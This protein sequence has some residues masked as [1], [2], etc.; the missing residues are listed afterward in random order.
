MDTV[1]MI[2]RLRSNNKSQIE[3]HKNVECTD[4]MRVE[5]NWT[6]K[7]NSIDIY[8]DYKYAFLTAIRIQDTVGR[9]PRPN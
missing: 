6:E 7:V 3:R 5:S 2:Y 9:T 4:A 8:E 1:G